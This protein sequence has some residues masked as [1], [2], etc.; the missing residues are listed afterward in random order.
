MLKA[1]LLSDTS[2]DD[3]HGCQIVVSQMHRFAAAVGIRIIWSS[4]VRNDWCN[5]HGLLRSTR[6]CMLKASL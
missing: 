1:V 3:H 2:Y 4:P 6:R 5:D